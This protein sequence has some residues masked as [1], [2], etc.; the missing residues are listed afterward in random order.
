MRGPRLKQGCVQMMRRNKIS[1]QLF[2]SASGKGAGRITFRQRGSAF[3]SLQCVG[4]APYFVFGKWPQPSLA[5]GSWFQS[6]DF[7]R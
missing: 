7:L 5:W 3:L 6:F 4:Q 2:S 1:I